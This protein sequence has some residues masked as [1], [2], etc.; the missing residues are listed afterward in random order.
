MNW[1][2]FRDRLYKIGDF[3]L[4]QC[5]KL[6]LFR[7]LTMKSFQAIITAALVAFVIHVRASPTGQDAKPSKRA[8]SSIV[9]GTPFG[10]ASSVTGGGDATPVYPTTIDELKS[11]LTSS[12][13]Q[14]IVI[15]GEFNFVGSEGTT[16]YEAC[17]P[18]DCTIAEGG[19][20]LL[21]TL[22]G[23]GSSTTFTATLDAASNGIQVAS[24]KTLVGKNSA[25]LNGKGL[26]MSGV[27]NIIIQNIEITNLN[28]QYVWGGDAIT[29]DN[30]NQIWIDHVTVRLHHDIGGTDKLT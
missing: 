6:S 20:G 1:S 30:T 14:N 19:Q 24:D 21:N 4:I 28:P 2:I 5:E 26:L 23:C 10:M 13:P 22:G 12:S 29:L 9:T 16:T 3:V 7:N 8:V 15:S 11:Y 18:Y 27:S 17:E 25:T